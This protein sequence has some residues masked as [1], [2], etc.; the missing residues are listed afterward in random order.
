MQLVMVPLPRTSLPERFLAQLEEA[1]RAKEE[2]KTPA[3]D[4][5]IPIGITYIIVVESRKLT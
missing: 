3:N 2:N 5:N 1:A 4:K